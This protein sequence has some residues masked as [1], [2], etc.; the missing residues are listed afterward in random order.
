MIR[1][2]W[3]I[4]Q[5]AIDQIEALHLSLKVNK[6]LC[7][8]LVG[9]GIS[10]YEEAEKFFRPKLIYL[11]DPFLMKD[12]DKAVER[13]L[14]AFSS[15]QKILV[16]G[17]YDVDGTTSVA[18]MYKFLQSIFADGLIEFYIPH[19]YRE[20]YGVSRMGIDYAPRT[21]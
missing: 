9:R 18:S 14:Q 16:F 12:M 17:D 7:A 5:P 3:K 11:H 1:K 20:G 13:I 6:K 21:S 19:R 8:I 15:Q 10:T 2:R 4:K